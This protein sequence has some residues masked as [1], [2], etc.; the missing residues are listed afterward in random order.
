MDELKEEI[1][2][3]RNK[4]I[5]TTK[6]KENLTNEDIVAI[7]QELDKKIVELMKKSAN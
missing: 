2:N 6:D 4:M 5:K 3:L 1:E 7:S